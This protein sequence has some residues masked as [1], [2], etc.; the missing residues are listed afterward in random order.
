[1][2]V[3]V[4]GRTEQ[5]GDVG[6]QAQIFGMGAVAVH[7][8]LL[9]PSGS[10]HCS[11]TLPVFVKN[12][13]HLW[14]EVSSGWA[15]PEQWAVGVP[16]QNVGAAGRCCCC[17]LSPVA[18]SLSRVG[19]ALQALLGRAVVPN[20]KSLFCLFSGTAAILTGLVLVGNHGIAS[21]Y[22]VANTPPCYAFHMEL[23]P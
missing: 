10:R 15:G 2:C 20:G 9:T 12:P 4:L 18:L 8:L 11:R 23:G 1:M 17:S 3:K 6:K 21:C 22:R 13:P 14:V 19:A 5:L 7:F 16:Q